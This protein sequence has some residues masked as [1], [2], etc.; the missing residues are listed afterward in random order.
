MARVALLIVCGACLL[1]GCTDGGMNSFIAAPPAVQ[2][3]QTRAIGGMISIVNQGKV[4]NDVV[5]LGTIT[6][7]H[8]KVEVLDDA[9]TGQ[10]NVS[11]MA[12][13]TFQASDELKPLAATW[14]AIGKSMD[15]LELSEAKHLFV[16]KQYRIQGIAD[17]SYISLTYEICPCTVACSKMCKY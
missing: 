15:R 2:G 11:I 4:Y 17:E 1:L 6:Y 13:M 14:K 12:E 5:V 8:S 10:Y 9:T 7:T 16:T 3:P